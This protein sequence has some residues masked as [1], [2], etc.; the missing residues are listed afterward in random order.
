[1]G[2]KHQQVGLADFQHTDE[3]EGNLYL[4]PLRINEK[5]E[6]KPWEVFP[7][8]TTISCRDETGISFRRKMTVHVVVVVC[9][10]RA[11]SH[12]CCCFAVRQRKKRGFHQN[13]WPPPPPAEDWSRVELTTRVSVD[14][15]PPSRPHVA[16][17]NVHQWNKILKRR[18]CACL[19]VD[20]LNDWRI[21]KE[22]D[23]QKK[24]SLYH[25]SALIIS[26]IAYSAAALCL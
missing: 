11:M 7:P 2:R 1:M 26:K 22:G 13:L 23:K 3:Y 5:K 25:T 19:I 15:R 16:P 18:L 6:E 8:L 14:C 10:L 21:K 12:I 24:A 9:V 4:F 20:S 17:T